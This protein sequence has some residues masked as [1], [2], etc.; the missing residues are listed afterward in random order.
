[1]L[2]RKKTKDQLRVTLWQ[3]AGVGAAKE[4]DK[5]SFEGCALVGGQ[6]GQY[7]VGNCAIRCD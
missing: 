3:V 5:R 1:V 2:Q 6:G 4:K 7:K